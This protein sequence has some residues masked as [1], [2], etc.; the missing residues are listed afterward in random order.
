MIFP[1]AALCL[2]VLAHASPVVEAD[3]KAWPSRTASKAH[4]KA[5]AANFAS[6]VESGT[7]PKASLSKVFNLV[8]HV[9]D[10]SR[11]LNPSI[12]GYSLT[13]SR[14]G[15]ASSFVSI[16]PRDNES[17]DTYASYLSGTAEEVAAGESNIVTDLS[18][19]FSPYGFSFSNDTGSKSL[20][21]VR[22]DPGAGTKGLTLSQLPSPISELIPH[23][24]LACNE[25]VAK[26]NNQ[27]LTI[28][29]NLDTAVDATIP[30]NCVPIRVFPEC[31]EFDNIYEKR[32]KNAGKA[33][34]T[35]CYQRGADYSKL[36]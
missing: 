24:F 14:D 33:Q 1:T 29:R 27:Y 12:E 26:Y 15:Y 2:A 32:K 17:K 10:K 16:E 35:R 20:T 11:D 13:P 28:L 25:T 7:V 34:P 23:K 9:T 18:K 19:F 22:Q 31:V 8:V 30:K 36:D 4:A 6:Q 5:F 3:D 21:Q